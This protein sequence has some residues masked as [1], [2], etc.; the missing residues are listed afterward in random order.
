MT[1]PGEAAMLGAALG[2]L[3]L[4][5]VALQIWQ[6]RTQYRRFKA[7]TASADRQRM[8]RYWVVDS[9][10][11]YG[12]LGLVGL[13]LLARIDALWAL[14]ADIAAARDGLFA[15]LGLSPD[16]AGNGVV[17]ALA[18]GVGILG[19]GLA[20]FFV[21]PKPG[22][23]APVIGDI[24]PLLPRNRAEM[25]WGALLALNAGMSE[26]IF[27]R[28]MTPLALYA[29]TGDM[30]LA[31]GG[32][33]TLFG[34]VHAYQGIVGVIATFA[35]GVIMTF[36]YLATG[37]LWVPILLHALIDLRAMVLTP[38]ASGALKAPA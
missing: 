15:T 32:A 23:A 37:Q 16:G 33:A 30:V 13:F 31:F 1:A 6:D 19:G 36:L 5:M 18:L 35:V 28:A 21:K 26:E 12:V 25:S 20:P 11:R 27:F 7:M 10:L 9:L 24:E 8:Y 2:V 14:P 4:A 34:L 22:Q 3:A 38:W 29:A 17:I